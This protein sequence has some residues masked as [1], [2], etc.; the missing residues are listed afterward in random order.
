VDMVFRK[1]RIETISCVYFGILIALFLTYV[2]GFAMEPLFYGDSMQVKTLKN[3]IQ[4]AIGVALSYICISL[5]FQTRDDFR[6][7]IPFV[8]FSK[9]V[10]GVKPYRGQVADAFN[11]LASGCHFIASA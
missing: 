4:L 11:K 3:V 7:I 9:E 2:L 6:F 10:K 1:K 5:L 8:E